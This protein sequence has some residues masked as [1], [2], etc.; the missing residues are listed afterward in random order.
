MIR[1]KVDYRT[2]LEELTLAVLEQYYVLQLQ[3][4]ANRGGFSDEMLLTS[5]SQMLGIDF[6]SA[7]FRTWLEQRVAY[8]DSCDE[9]DKRIH[10]AALKSG[11]KIALAKPLLQHFVAG[12]SAFSEDVAA[13]EEWYSASKL[14]DSDDE[15]P[16]EKGDDLK[17]GVQRVQQ[18]NDTK[19]RGTKRLRRE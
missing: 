5:V 1:L 3:T 13:D 2:T 18:I 17:R 19:R 4:P 10:T 12:D 6:E 15:S 7:S 9:G 11:G 14:T 8:V 16:S